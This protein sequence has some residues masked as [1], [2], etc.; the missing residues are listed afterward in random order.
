LG[1]L[2]DDDDG[3]EDVEPLEALHLIEEVSIVA[4][5]NTSTAEESG[6]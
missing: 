5:R 3:G 2:Y 4:A 1:Y 6:D